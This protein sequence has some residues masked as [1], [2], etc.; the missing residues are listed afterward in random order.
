MKHSK[1]IITALIVSI[2]VFNIAC[3]TDITIDLPKPEEKLIVQGRVENGLRPFVFLSRNTGYF[4]AVEIP[5]I[6]ENSN[7]DEIQQAMTNSLGV[8]YDSTILITVSDGSLTDTLRPTINI[9]KFPYFG[10]QAKT[11]VGEFGKNYRLEINYKNKFYWA[12][13]NIPYPVDIDSVSFEY[14]SN[15]D[16]CGNLNFLIYDN[17]NTR[18]FYFMETQVL[19]EQ[20]DFYR[21]YLSSSVFDDEFSNHDTIYISPLLRGFEENDFLNPIHYTKQSFDENDTVFIENAY[22]DFGETVNIKLSSIDK[23]SFL[24]WMSF[25]KH[26]STASNPFTNPASLKSNIHGENCEGI[27]AGHAS[28][29]TTVEIN[30]SLIKNK[31]SILNLT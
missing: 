23:D 27:W 31:H 13:T 4:E 14:A 17:P 5:K 9:L 30:E 8:I 7:L 25:Y 29:I 16:T 1:H 19:G 6:D 22:Y 28:S 24:F 3:E 12:S 20:I 2:V 15:N 10:Y 26:L 18:N 11:L 21:P